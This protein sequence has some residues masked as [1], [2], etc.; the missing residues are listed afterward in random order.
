MFL[1]SYLRYRE[2]CKV[3]YLEYFKSHNLLSVSASSPELGFEFKTGISI[4]EDTAK[5]IVTDNKIPKLLEIEKYLPQPFLC[6]PIKH[7]GTL[8]G[9]VLIRFC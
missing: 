9:L 1:S 4:S 5:A 2:N 3:V 7:N 6:F 8:F